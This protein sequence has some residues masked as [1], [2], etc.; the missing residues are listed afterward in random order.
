LPLHSDPYDFPGTRIIKIPVPS[1]DPY[2]IEFRDDGFD[3]DDGPDWHL[4]PEWQLTA[5]INR[6][7]GT[8]YITAQ[9][10]IGRIGA[11]ERFYDGDG[12]FKLEVTDI[13]EAAPHREITIQVTFAPSITTGLIAH[14]E[15]N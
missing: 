8:Q 10:Y 15:P 14:Q 11:G 2:Y 1:G 9:T 12:N 7:D 5:V 13:S 6:W 3:F 4:K